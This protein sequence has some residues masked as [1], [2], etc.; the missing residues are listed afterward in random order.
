MIIVRLIREYYLN[1]KHKKIKFKL[2][3]QVQQMLQMSRQD[4]MY[5]MNVSLLLLSG[6]PGYKI[7]DFFLAYFVAGE[8]AK[9]S[10][11]IFQEVMP[12]RQQEI[13][14]H[15][16]E[17]ERQVIEEFNNVN[18]NILTPNDEQVLWEVVNLFIE[19]GKSDFD[20]EDF[21][22]RVEKAIEYSKMK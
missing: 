20:Y 5:F 19:E 8:W 16:V 17:N 22:Q 15:L 4:V 6:K 12:F 14:K 3:E 1:Y 13:A 2:M 11:G 9:K 18:F 7:E 21:K 10:C